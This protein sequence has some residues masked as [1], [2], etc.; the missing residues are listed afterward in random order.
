MSPLKQ[1]LVIGATGAQGIPVVRALSRDRAYAVRAMTRNEDSADAKLIAGWP[2]VELFVGD[3]CDEGDLRKAFRG[4][5]GAFVN[6]N[7]YV[8]GEKGEIYWGE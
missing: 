3:C 8:T 1:I 7:G 5:K 6:T 4:V 2:N